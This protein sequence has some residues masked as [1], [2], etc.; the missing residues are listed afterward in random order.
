MAKGDVRIAPSIT[1]L[2]I[3]K[4]FTSAWSYRHIDQLI[5]GGVNCGNNNGKHRFIV[6]LDEDTF[7]EILYYVVV[8]GV[9]TDKMVSDLFQNYI[10]ERK[11]RDG[12]N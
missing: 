9:N 3:S 4:K 2:I 11:K 6:T 12:S 5:L 1:K 8:E 10:A 7:H